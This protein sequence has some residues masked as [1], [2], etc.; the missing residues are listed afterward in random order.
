MLQRHEAAIDTAVYWLHGLLVYLGHLALCAGLALTPQILIRFYDRCRRLYG[1]SQPRGEEHPLD[2]EV[3]SPNPRS[4]ARTPRPT[5]RLPGALSLTPTP[6]S[7]TPA[8]E[9]NVSATSTSSREKGQRAKSS[10][11]D[12]PTLT[13]QAQKVE[14]RDRPGAPSKKAEVR[15]ES[16]CSDGKRKRG[17]ASN[18]PSTR[19]R[20]SDSIDTPSKRGRK[21]QA[22]F[23]EKS[24][25][26][27]TRVGRVYTRINGA[28]P[29]QQAGRRTT[30]APQ[31]T[32]RAES[33]HPAPP[34]Q[35]PRAKR[36]Q[37]VIT[38]ERSKAR[39]LEQ[40]ARPGQVSA[41]SASKGRTSTMNR[42]ATGSHQT[43]NELGT[44]PRTR[45][46]SRRTV[47]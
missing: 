37:P 24:A 6:K 15:P 36:A 44:A 11:P 31:A 35:L 39:R 22:P 23:D 27:I 3:P 30:R 10:P 14:R 32:V 20:N 43:S 18:S 42:R 17:N 25:P 16:P 38:A 21:Q 19:E 26:Q 4:K 5:P 12:S 7:D 9:R 8:V 40:D 1:H 47:D 29:S 41:A 13:V 45:S 28:G 33:R 34:S 2:G 46:Q